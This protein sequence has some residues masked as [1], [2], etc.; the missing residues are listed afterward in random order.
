MKQQLQ[1]SGYT[2]YWDKS[3][4]DY[5]NE[6]QSDKWL[7]QYIKAM[8]LKIVFNTTH[9]D[10]KILKVDLWNEGVEKTRNILSH[11]P[12][13]SIGFDISKQTCIM[14]KR[15]ITQEVAQ[16]SCL[17]LPYKTGYF[18]AVLDLSTIDHIALLSAPKV[19]SEYHRILR[20]HGI[21]SLVFWQH[22]FPTKY[23]LNRISDQLYFD[24]KTVQNMLKEAGFK[25]QKAF[26]IG[27]LMTINE[28]NKPIN[29]AFWQ[30]KKVL[31]KKLIDLSLELEFNLP[32]ILGGL[33][34]IYASK[35]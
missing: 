20:H 21:L 27:S 13:D 30:I 5:P 10:W 4:K 11:L 32:N 25:V 1:P 17:D 28:S 33:R 7:K 35:P 8:Y 23:I 2:E 14:A 31:E 34:V 9:P 18:D 22:S 29:F 16:A 6:M 3:A 26:N 12:N 15:N 24:Q 19:F